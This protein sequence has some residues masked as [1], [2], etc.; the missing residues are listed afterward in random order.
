MGAQAHVPRDSTALGLRGSQPTPAPA[1]VMA[2]RRCGGVDPQPRGRIHTALAR[3][4]ITGV[5]PNPTRTL[6]GW[7][8]GDGTTDPR[9]RRR[10][11]KS[12]EPLSP[13]DHG[14]TGK[15][16]APTPAPVM[17]GRGNG[18]MDPRLGRIMSTRTPQPGSP[19]M[20]AA[21]FSATRRMRPAA[22]TRPG[23]TGGPLAPA[24]AP[25]ARGRRSAKPPPR[26]GIDV[27]SPTRPASSTAPPPPPRRN[28]PDVSC[29]SSHGARPP[30][31]TRPRSPPPLPPSLLGPPR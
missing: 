6:A 5:P 25:A 20:P 28:S 23:S 4:A 9:P 12:S 18:S 27:G 2:G 7:A 19:G 13:T 1:P 14:S 21:P 30:P 26:A 29:P 11:A 17:T 16:L 3:P 10:S 24:Q 22:P 15:P 8:R 31:R